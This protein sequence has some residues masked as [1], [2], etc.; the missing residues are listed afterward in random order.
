VLPGP[1]SNDALGWSVAISADGLTAVAGAIGQGSGTGAVYVFTRSGP[2]WL[3]AA[4]LT[5]SDAVTGDDFGYSVAISAGSVLVGANLKNSVRGAAYVF[6]GHGPAW[7]QAAELTAS[8][9]AI[10]DFFGSSVA[11][12]AAGRTAL[13][14]VYGHAA[15]AGAAYVFAGLPPR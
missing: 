4:E 14:G 11:I 1:A 8:D 10:G 5:A 15:V 12:S 6:T 9:G 7:H 3:R 13:I 2:G